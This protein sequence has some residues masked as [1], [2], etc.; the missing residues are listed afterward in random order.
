MAVADTDVNIFE[1]TEN[2]GNGGGGGGGTT[3]VTIYS[4][5]NTITTEEVSPGEWDVNVASESSLRYLIHNF[6]EFMAASVDV[7]KKVLNGDSTNCV[8]Q[9]VNDIDMTSPTA[10]QASLYRVNGSS[11][12]DITNKRY[13]FGKYFYRTTIM[14]DGTAR[15]I[16]LTYPNGTNL[17]TWTFGAEWI[18]MNNVVFGGGVAS[19]ARFPNHGAPHVD[20]ANFSRYLVRSNGNLNY[21]FEN[22]E[23]TCCGASSDS[24]NPFIFEGNGSNNSGTPSLYHTRLRLE[25]CYFFHGADMGGSVYNLTVAPI[26]IHS[27]Q[28]GGM[29]RS[30]KIKQLTKSVGQLESELGLPNIQIRSY[31]PGTTSFN[32]IKTTWEA[33]PWQTTGDGTALISCEVSPECLIFQTKVAVNDVFIQGQPTLQPEGATPTYN[34]VSLVAELLKRLIL[35]ITDMGANDALTDSDQIYFQGAANTATDANVKRGTLSKLW[36]WI[37]GK[38][39]NR[40]F[41]RYDFVNMPNNSFMNDLRYFSSQ[42]NDRLWAADQRF[43]VT[44][45]GHSSETDEEIYDKDTTAYRLFLGEVGM[46]AAHPVTGEYDIIKIKSKTEGSSM[47][48]YNNGK[49][50]LSFYGGAVPP[51]PPVIRV[52][53]GSPSQWITL[54]TPSNPIASVYVYTMPTGANSLYLKE[55]EIKVQGRV[56]GSDPNSAGACLSSIVFI[57]ERSS[58]LGESLVTKY[59]VDQQLYGELTA[60]K[61]ITR[62]GTSSQVVAG[63]GSLLSYPASP[64][65]NGGEMTQQAYNNMGSHDPNTIYVITD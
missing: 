58:V 14:C 41:A 9:I 12:I 28:G 62:G 23:I 26:V 13:N 6:D 43:N 50:I 4:S 29:E 24:F 40:Y 48:T 25:N 57:C 8:F 64:L 17:D 63:D 60:K 21:V 5:R 37:K 55:I 36:S 20:T 54:G 39:D 22:C 42:L 46:Y 18:R 31:N 44:W 16:Q 3:D 65:N 27:E 61:I 33:R 53:T 7:A 49:L 32:N 35:K 45:R 10:E 15:T 34:W 2:Y 56:P 47:W 52:Y 38:A 19:Y 11:L 30:F 59:A 1:D 51:T